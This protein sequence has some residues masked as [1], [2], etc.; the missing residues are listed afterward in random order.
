MMPPPKVNM[1]DLGMSMPQPR[2][3]SSIAASP[4]RLQEL[5]EAIKSEFEMVGNDIQLYKMQRDDLEHKLTAQI[6]ELSAFQQSLYELERAHQKIKQQYEDEILRLRRD[7]EARG[8]PSQQ[9]A[10]VQDVRH[11]QSQRGGP[12]GP[13]SGGPVPGFPEGVPPPVLGGG[14]AP[15]GGAGGVFSALMSGADPR[16]MQPPYLN[17]NNQ[18]LPSVGGNPNDNGPVGTPGGKR[19][20]VEESGPYHYGQPNQSGGSERER[21]RDQQQREKKSKKSN[22]P[23]GPPDGPLP[24][25]SSGPGG[26]YGHPYHPGSSA[27]PK[28]QLQSLQQSSQPPMSQMLPPASQQHPPHPHMHAQSRP[29]TPPYPTAQQQMQP[30]SSRPPPQEYHHPNSALGASTAYGSAHQVTGICELPYVEPEA[31]PPRLQ[32]SGP[33]WWAFYNPKSAALAKNKIEVKLVHSLEHDSVVCCV[34]FSLDGRMLATGCNRVAYVWDAQTGAKISTLTDSDLSPTTD[35]YIRSVC[36]SPDGHFLA[37]GA[38]DRIIRIWDIQRRKVV[39]A[40]KGHEQDIYSLDWSRD[41]RVIVSGSGDRSVKVWDAGNGKCLM[42][43]LGDDGG[44]KSGEGRESRDR[45]GVKDSGVTSIAV[46]PVDGRS[47]A[48]GSL[49]EEVRLFDL[50]TG[51]LLERFQGH[52][53]SVYSVAF[54]PDGRSIV[55]GS[56]DRTLK[57][58]DLSPQTLNYLRSNPMSV[59]QEYETVVTRV[60][61]HTFVGHQDYVLSVGFAGL[62]SVFG[63]V[64]EHGDVVPGNEALQ[65]VEWVVSG[66]KDRNVIF[67]DGRS[68]ATHTANVSGGAGSTNDRT[69]VSQFLLQGHKNSV[70]SVALSS[71]GGLFA[72]G[73]GDWRARI[74]RIMKS[75]GDGDSREGREGRNDREGIK[76]E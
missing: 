49:D 16:G 46:N 68:G 65:D 18:P 48:A 22:M 60:S 39:L 3:V 50:R 40:L 10:S 33:D 1:K 72:T 25:P 64:D 76:M 31:F 20:R 30:P 29:M 47:V 53:N 42:S 74:W 2:D 12:S 75:E 59:D 34:K 26:P 32:S 45:E 54:S 37:T 38:E 4:T 13:V 73:S 24:P 15:A 9:Q 6:T 14:H 70:I 71:V 69:S 43:V 7:L 27:G 52:K 62:G 36:F 28:A 56:L 51:A 55:S 19:L 57:I 66:S 63:R 8:L 61:R 58:W 11:L 23:Q 35:L 21:E 17:G 67:W 41:G 5:F 44:G